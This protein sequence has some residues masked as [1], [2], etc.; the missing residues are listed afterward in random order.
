[1]GRTADHAGDPD[2][3]DRPTGFGAVYAGSDGRFYTSWEL[4]TNYRRDRWRDC[5][6]HGDGR[7]LVAVG[8]S[9]LL[10]TPVRHEALPEWVDIRVC[11]TRVGDRRP[12]TVAVD[13]RGSPALETRG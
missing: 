10:L 9:L 4:L 1:M 8:E 12:R 11:R 3:A 6:R 7:R 13:T 5:L 2:D